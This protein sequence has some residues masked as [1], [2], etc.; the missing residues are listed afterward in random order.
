MGG[1]RGVIAIVFVR[2]KFELRWFQRSFLVLAPRLAAA[3]QSP[4]QRGR[5]CKPAGAGEPC[6]FLHLGGKME[7]H[8]NA[9]GWV[10]GGKMK[11]ANAVGERGFDGCTCVQ[12]AEHLDRADRGTSEGRRDVVGDTCEAKHADVE[13][14]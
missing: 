13:L 3:E 12:G 11:S 9:F 6:R 5:L 1:L 14:L 8:A 4:Q 2:A 7:V 10:G